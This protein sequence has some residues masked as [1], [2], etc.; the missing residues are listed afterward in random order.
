MKYV[1]IFLVVCCLKSCDTNKEVSLVENNIIAFDSLNIS[2]SLIK[3]VV[4]EN[5]TADTIVVDTITTSCECI[6]LLRKIDNLSPFGKDSI[7]FEF[8][9]NKLGY[10]SRG[11]CIQLNDEFI[12]I[13]IEGLIVGNSDSEIE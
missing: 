10:V 1:I 11:L 12:D 7:I 13:I 9:P 2:D 5:R 6:T 8:V 3:S 4:L